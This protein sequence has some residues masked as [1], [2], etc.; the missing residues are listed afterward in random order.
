M[1]VAE[2]TAWQKMSY[3][4]HKNFWLATPVPVNETKRA[5]RN[6]SPFSTFQ[7]LSVAK[8]LQCH[9]VTAFRVKPRKQARY[10]GLDTAEPVRLVS[11]KWLRGRR[12]RTSAGARCQSRLGADHGVDPQPPRQPESPLPELPHLHRLEADPQ[13]T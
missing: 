4:P 5:F 11:A 10:L 2:T 13:R 7:L 1:H 12:T 8:R 3:V 9:W 6:V